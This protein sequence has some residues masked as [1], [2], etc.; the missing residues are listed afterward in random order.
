M[1]WE[2]TKDCKKKHRFFA[3]FIC[4]IFVMERV[5][6]SILRSWRE[7]DKIEVVSDINILCM[8]TFLVLRQ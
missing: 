7:T 4:Q 3:L 8:S 6:E 5:E 2:Q 1:K